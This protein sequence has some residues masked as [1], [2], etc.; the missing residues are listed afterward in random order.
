MIANAFESLPFQVQSSLS[1][2]GDSLLDIS[3]D[4][5]KVLQVNSYLPSMVI[6][7]FKLIAFIYVESKSVMDVNWLNLR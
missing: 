4:L 7:F 5:S 3:S 1:L 6:R 2:T